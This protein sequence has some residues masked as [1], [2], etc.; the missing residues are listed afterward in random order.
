MRGA[1]ILIIDDDQHVFENVRNLLSNLAKGFEWASLPEQGIRLAIQSQPDVILLDVNMPGMDGLKVCRHLKETES[2]RDIPVIFLT[3]ERN[4]SS[5]ARALACGGSDYIMKPCNEVDLRARVRV[6]L[7]SKRMIDLL[8]EQARIDALTGL[9][10]RAAMDQ[11]L[12]S[13]VASH[14]RLGQPFALLMVDID[15]FKEINDRHGHG[16]GDDVLR[17]VA[18][19]LASRC[20]PYDVACRYGGDEFGIVLGQTEGEHAERASTRILDG[21]RGMMGND[22]GEDLTVTCSGGLASTAEM[23]PGFNAEDVIKAADG[24]LYLAKQA[25]RDQLQSARPPSG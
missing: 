2:T 21:V 14:E 20:R 9:S 13:C 3:V 8:K 25:G 11:A 10:N 24:A 15:H 4:L 12:S 22:D 19:A 1:R 17:D 6:A 18:A 23:P 7:R 5:L 16:V